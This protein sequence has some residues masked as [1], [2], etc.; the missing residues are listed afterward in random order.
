MIHVAVCTPLPALRAGLRALISADP[1]L[2]VTASAA[3]LE[4]LAGM[5]SAGS[6][7]PQ[8]IVATAEGAGRLAD[9]VFTGEDQ[10]C[11]LLLVSD[12][13]RLVRRLAENAAGMPAW[14]AI[15][16]NASG[17]ALQAAIHALAGGLLVFSPEVFETRLVS[18][19]AANESAGGEAEGIIEALTPREHEILGFL[20]QGLTNKQIALGLGISEHTV[21]FHVSS[22]YSKLGASNR[23]EAVRKGARRGWVAL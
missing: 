18:Q 14:G 8:V 7:T 10:G 22:V 20:A 3:T 6:P 13:P 21:K 2:D 12:D 11:A 1:D 9:G 16:P 5:Q 23:T 19:G 4:E 15:S 17:E